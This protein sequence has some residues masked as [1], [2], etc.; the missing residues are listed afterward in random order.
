MVFFDVA[1][2]VVRHE[3]KIDDAGR[4]TH[5]DCI[6]SRLPSTFSPVIPAWSDFFYIMDVTSAI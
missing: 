1:R 6:G 4:A 5:Y 3:I 2:K